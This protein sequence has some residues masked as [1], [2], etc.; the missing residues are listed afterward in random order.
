[1]RRREPAFPKLPHTAKIGACWVVH[2]TRVGA[3][4][5]FCP[6]RLRQQLWIALRSRAPFD[7]VLVHA[8][9]VDDETLIGMG[10]TVL[11]G[12]IIGKQCIIGAN[13]LVK[14]GHKIPDGSLVLGSPAKIIRPLSE[15]ERASL[16][17]WADK[18][19]ANAAYCIEKKIN[20]GSRLSS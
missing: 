4:R 14:Q 17:G 8:C 1:M 6:F 2:S 5:L 12:A 20:L 13:A 10:A 9:R 11:D 7:H 16:K 15:E 19:V 3:P 18:Y